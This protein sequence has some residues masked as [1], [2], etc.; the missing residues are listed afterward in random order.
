MK[1]LNTFVA[2][3]TLF[4]TFQA[5][6][7]LT[8]STSSAGTLAKQVSTPAEVTS[9]T[10]S[11]P[12]DA[13]DIYF[14]GK[15]MTALASLD[16]SG[17][18]IEGYYNSPINGISTFAANVIPTGAF[19]GLPL[20]EVVLPATPGLIIADCAFQGT[21]LT[22]LSLPA[23]VDSVGMGAF[24]YCTE[25]KT[26]VFPTTQRLGSDIFADCA[27]L[28]TVNLN[29]A[30][31]IPGSTFRNCPALAEVTGT[32]NVS[33]IGDDA[34]KGDAALTAFKFGKSLTYLGDAAFAG[35]SITDV[36]LTEST[37][38]D[39]IGDRAFSHSAVETATLPDNLQTIGTGSFIDTRNLTDIHIPTGTITISDHALKG[40]ALDSIILPDGLETIGDHAF[41]DLNKISRIVLPS[42]LI[43][44]GDYA[45]KNMT[46]LSEIYAG[47]LMSVPETGENVWDGVDQPLVSLKVKQN[48]QEEF[49]N[50][51]QWKDFN[52]ELI[53][54]ADDVVN[55]ITSPSVRGRF[56]GTDLEIVSTGADLSSV[57]LFDTAGRLIASVEPHDTSAVIDTAGYSA[58]VYVITVILADDTKATLKLGRR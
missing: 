34:F 54:G 2:A 43:R 11:G 18:N 24:S 37:R 26:V 12:I 6:N 44:V 32:Q 33:H 21:K 39:K 50:A 1:I 7:A 35:T 5:A 31:V 22:S 16:L 53:T 14:I 10:L 38:L 13:S 42:T 20:A 49:S 15:E 51:P 45:M 48:T 3:A 17:A 55:D 58:G 28:S 47:E 46:G 52:I 29:G 4:A 9:L 19:A 30:K 27:S 40:A 25:L 8:V 23:N 57:R 36:D 41:M 56:V